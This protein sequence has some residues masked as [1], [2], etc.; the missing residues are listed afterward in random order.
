MH[1]RSAK[2][3]LLP[4]VILG[5]LVGFLIYQHGVNQ[6]SAAPSSPGSLTAQE[7]WDR[8]QQGEL[9]IVDVRR[10]EEWRQTGTPQGAVRLSFETHP[11][12][13]EG[14]THD[15]ATALGEDKTKP[16]AII[17]RTGNR[18]GLLLPF[19]QSKGFTAAKAIPEGMVGSS[20]G[21]GWL[22]H[23]LPIDS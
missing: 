8:V 16:F 2:F 3:F 4:V 13:P 18:T 15:L 7:A 1:L 14:F 17:C 11:G 20:A 9:T 19:L 12:G 23:G 5:L 21:R 10:P 22:R 6:P